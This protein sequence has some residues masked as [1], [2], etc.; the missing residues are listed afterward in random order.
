MNILSYL[1]EN[2]DIL[3][4]DAKVAFGKM[5]R[6]DGGI[7]T[8]KFFTCVYTVFHH[9]VLYLDK[10]LDS[11]SL[12]DR[13]QLMC[14]KCIEYLVSNWSQSSK[15]SGLPQSGMLKLCVIVLKK[16][17]QKDKYVEAENLLRHMIGFYIPSSKG[18]D[19]K[20]IQ[21]F[22][23]I[24]SSFDGSTY[25]GSA[26]SYQEM[27]VYNSLI[28]SRLLSF[29]NLKNAGWKGDNKLIV[30]FTLRIAQT[31]LL[32]Q[33]SSTNQ[34]CSCHHC[35]RLADDIIN[36]LHLLSSGDETAYIKLFKHIVLL[37]CELLR[38][39]AV[40]NQRPSEDNDC[41]AENT[42]QSFHISQLW[43]KVDENCTQLLSVLPDI[44]GRH[45][46]SLQRATTKVIV[47]L[48]TSTEI[49]LQSS[50]QQLNVQ[51]SKEMFGQIGSVVCSKVTILE[52]DLVD[53]NCVVK[54]M[55]LLYRLLQ[56]HSNK[57]KELS[58]V[59]LVQLTKLFHHSKT[60]LIGTKDTCNT[61][62][63]NFFLDGTCNMCILAHQ[64]KQTSYKKLTCALLA[65]ILQFVTKYNDQLCI[66]H[67]MQHLKRM[68]SLLVNINNDLCQW[69][70]SHQLL[71]K[72][73]FAMKNHQQVFNA[74]INSF[75]VNKQYWSNKVKEGKE[76]I[77]QSTCASHDDDIDGV[78]GEV[79]VQALE[80]ELQYYFKI[81]RTLPYQEVACLRAILHHSLKHGFH[82]KYITYYFILERLH[83]N[84]S[85]QVVPFSCLDGLADVR[86]M[87]TSDNLE[88]MEQMLEDGQWEWKVIE[89]SNR[90]LIWWEDDIC[91]T[92]EA[93]VRQ[94]K[95]AKKQSS[96]RGDDDDC[97]VLNWCTQS[98]RPLD[99]LVTYLPSK[100]IPHLLH[101]KESTLNFHQ[102]T[103]P[104][105]SILTVLLRLRGQTTE[106]MALLKGIDNFYD[107][108]YL[109]I[110]DD[111]TRFNYLLHWI[112][113]K[114]ELAQLMAQ[115]YDKH[116]AL[117]L[118][119]QA[120]DIIHNEL[121]VISTSSFNVHESKLNCMIMLCKLKRKIAMV[122]VH[123]A[124]KQ[125]TEAWTL[126]TELF[127]DDF[128]SDAR[129]KSSIKSRFAYSRLLLLRHQVLVACLAS[130]H[131]VSTE[132]P[133]G[134]STFFIHEALKQ[135]IV[136]LRL[137]CP[138]IS[139]F[140]P[141][142]LYDAMEEPIIEFFGRSCEDVSRDTV[143]QLELV[144][145]LLDVLYQ[146]SDTFLRCGN[147]RLALPPIIDGIHLS[148]HLV[149]QE[150]EL[151]FEYLMLRYTF[152]KL[153]NNLQQLKNEFIIC[154]ELIF[155]ISHQS[156]KEKLEKDPTVPLD[157]YSQLGK[158]ED[159]EQQ[160]KTGKRTILF[161]GDY[162]WQS[163][164]ED[165]NISVIEP[166]GIEDDDDDEEGVELKTKPLKLIK[167]SGPPS[168][169]NGS[170]PSLKPAVK[171][172][173][174][175][176]ETV[177]PHKGECNCRFCNNHMLQKD[178]LK[179]ATMHA[180][181]C[182]YDQDHLMALSYLDKVEAR[183]EMWQQ[184]KTND[185]KKIWEI[186]Q[187][188]TRTPH[189]SVFMEEQLVLTTTQLSILLATDSC[190]T[191]KLLNRTL[192][193][194]KDLSCIS[195]NW[196]GASAQLHLL[197]AKLSLRNGGFKITT[198][199]CT[200]DAIKTSNKVSDVLLNKM[201]DFQQ[202]LRGKVRKK[203]ATLPA[204]VEPAT[205]P[206]PSSCL[207]SIENKGNLLTTDASSTSTMLTY[208]S[209]TTSSMESLQISAKKKSV[210]KT[211]KRTT[212]RTTR[213][214]SSVKK[215]PLSCQ[216]KLETNASFQ[217]Y[218][219]EDSELNNP[220]KEKLTKKRTRGKLPCPEL[221][222]TTTTVTNSSR[223]K[224]SRRGAS[225]V[226]T[227]NILDETAE[228]HDTS[229]Q[230]APKRRATRATTQNIMK[231]RKEAR[232]RHRT[233]NGPC[234]DEDEE[235][236]AR[237]PARATRKK[238]TR[239]ATKK[240]ASPQP[241]K[242]SHDNPAYSFD[243]VETERDSRTPQQQHLLTAAQHAESPRILNT[244]QDN[245]EIAVMSADQ[246]LKAAY[247]LAA[248]TGDF[249]SF[250]E[251]CYLLCATTH[252]DVTT[253]CSKLPAAYHT[254]SV[255][256]TLRGSLN[257][258]TEHRLKQIKRL[259][260]KEFNNYAPE[261][262]H[263]KYISDYTSVRHVVDICSDPASYM[264][265][266]CDSLPPSWAV[267][268][269]SHVEMND[270]N[271]KGVY[272]TRLTNERQP[273]HTH[274][275]GNGV[276]DLLAFLQTTLEDSDKGLKLTHDKAAWW[277]YRRNADHRMQQAIDRIQNDILGY[278]CGLLL[279]GATTQRCKDHI[280][281]TYQQVQKVV[282]TLYP[283]GAVSYQLVEAMLGCWSHLS[284]TLR[285]AALLELLKQDSSSY[286][287]NQVL[288]LMEIF[289][290][291]FKLLLQEERGHVVLILDKQLQSLPW[292]SI[293]LLQ[294]HS[295]SR[296]PSID[297]LMWQL[298]LTNCMA[299][300]QTVD[301]NAVSYV[302]NP[303]GDLSSTDLR[304]KTWFNSIPRWDGVV[305]TAPTKQQWLEYISKYDA[306]LYCGHGTGQQFAGYEHI[307]SG[308]HH[309]CAMLM[310]C[311]SG[312]LIEYGETEPD[313]M[314]VAYLLSGA[315]SVVSCLWTVTDKDID[316]YTVKVV[317]EWMEKG[318]LTRVVRPSSEA[319]KLKRING[320]ACVVYGL[321]MSCSQVSQ[322]W[323]QYM[324]KEFKLL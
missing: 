71:P 258:K 169:E 121:L 80:C 147:L 84:W 310:G 320:A 98:Q 108:I 54:F 197:A 283:D 180:T 94:Q 56:K 11:S 262:A 9:T 2:E 237:P 210:G 249:S 231:K 143:E 1:S 230:V 83:F 101:Y 313:G 173:C 167:P 215:A 51:Y 217:I 15:S 24:H 315:P 36:S 203:V 62:H 155:S 89:I 261:E 159:W 68:A 151:H 195:T 196:Y 302:V 40:L 102:F 150:R 207:K 43:E 50:I 110:T 288:K 14:V 161:S 224:R 318:E 70:T 137:P 168:D 246:H 120:K 189:P 260:C 271:V 301:F 85:D 181:Y 149:L 218:V 185:W 22:L 248:A 99:A 103:I 111:E 268:I 295:V 250:K 216:T 226:T 278:H 264:D 77:F 171:K 307:L 117:Q 27:T 88:L 212:T 156:R 12:F 229:Q 267:C 274:L 273:F 138:A 145:F 312:K 48:L 253:V 49:G 34:C 227:E 35:H 152:H 282:A 245:E 67:T 125:L 82:D 297:I 233:M 221:P 322:E 172:L 93:R 182:M 128:V 298:K 141:K 208:L 275:D 135:A 175:K 199:K 289:E 106:V 47:E 114:C 6:G 170:A 188:K 286:C 311:K 198:I 30:N 321:P 55:Y 5:P 211:P 279:G 306:F 244:E 319:C 53:S 4:P 109:S 291:N 317:S 154:N 64:S 26:S 158:R 201:I 79:V 285:C 213:I 95:E 61:K 177:F 20:I 41:C 3:P 294:N 272:L 162:S 191:F 116:I 74:L 174:S 205:P 134:H 122:S 96:K 130:P 323:T 124:F 69:K 105:F 140:L 97:N 316:K 270:D 163:G 277:T 63:I 187:D 28:K 148:R 239:Y 142:L 157:L 296:I 18:D 184:R 126:M 220:K 144:E 78:D 136:L 259:R 284:E 113:V 115:H 236:G 257:A 209:P 153:P 305:G 200:D 193:Q 190:K 303:K 276:G 23:I 290:K 242:E 300:Y 8:P 75:T 37:H 280:E 186:H 127:N 202:K 304:F 247:K 90:Y 183:I 32:Q 86:M 13:V 292:E 42:S 252:C 123:L 192:Q 92:T 38:L 118:V 59:I 204:V 194:Q 119:T 65:D 232:T 228:E 225:S 146:S 241:S 309:S 165:D 58:K 160:V 7:K 129:V 139:K 25:T 222:D 33:T 234:Y 240:A 87:M 166:V 39:K 91:Q 66:D 179:L 206:H 235:E 219:E 251:A 17:K 19:E 133:S 132:L 214:P 73:I 60:I 243:V 238:S 314:A 281:E 269:I 131:L 287:I 263:L 81:K 44:D 45:G 299:M 266:I 254:L 100:L 46:S 10:V 72:L 29:I 104:S 107:M 52:N 31:L 164:D 308:P 324:P 57:N 112:T 16:L 76:E 176:F 265:D 256:V 293:N 178:V 255:G 223:P 21:L